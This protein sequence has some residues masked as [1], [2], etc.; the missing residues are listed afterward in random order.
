MDQLPLVL[1]TDGV[2]RR[3][4][5][6]DTVPL[7]F[8]GT[9]ATTAAAALANMGGLNSLNP[10]MTGIASVTIPSGATTDR[11]A[12]AQAEMRYNTTLACFEGYT[13]NG[14]VQMDND[15]LNTYKGNVPVV[16]GTTQIPYG[17]SAPLV[18]GGTQLWTQT[19]TPSF[20]NTNMEISFGSIVDCSSSGATITVALF[21]GSM[22]LAFRCAYVTTSNHPVCF[23]MKLN[24][25]PGS[26]TPV[27]Y[28]CRIGV[29]LSSTW[30]LGRPAS[31]SMG[32]VNLSGWSIKETF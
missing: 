2:T 7:L 28:S 10:V 9:G 31:S 11:P 5:S 24:H 22:L 13:S 3:M 15:S 18:T 21:A 4:Q 32:G 8:G 23:D 12:G 29:S 27:V 16:S 6:G 30:Y 20:S 14:W 25:A 17:T 26:V 19:V 1:Y